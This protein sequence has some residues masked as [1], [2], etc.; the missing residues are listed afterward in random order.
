MF[1]PDL[2]HFLQPWELV[3]RMKMR[4]KWSERLLQYQKELL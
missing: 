3:L 4:N 2:K 1:P